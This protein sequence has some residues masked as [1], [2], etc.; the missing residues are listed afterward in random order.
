MWAAS[1]FGRDIRR[2]WKVSHCRL[3]SDQKALSEFSWENFAFIIKT[4]LRNRYI[5]RQIHSSMQYLLLVFYEIERQYQELELLTCKLITSATP[6]Y[7]I[8]RPSLWLIYLTV[9]P[10][11][12]SNHVKD[13]KITKNNKLSLCTIL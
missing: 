5:Y 1:R 4:G 13:A 11:L 8:I 10:F 3:L 9:K 6:V 7:S 2:H 12:R